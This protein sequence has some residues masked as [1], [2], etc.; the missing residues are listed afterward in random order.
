MSAHAE[1]LAR[2]FLGALPASVMSRG[3][4]AIEGR[5][6]T[7]HSASDRRK[8]GQFGARL[9]KLWPYGY[10]LPCGSVYRHA[11]LWGAAN[12]VKGFQHEELIVGFGLARGSRTRIDS[13]MKIRGESERVVLPPNKASEIHSF[14]NE[15]ERHTVLF[16][17]NHP[18]GHPIL[19]LLGLVLGNDPLPSL[20]D[21]NFAIGAFITRL[22]TKMQ[23]L[24]FGRLRFYLVQNDVI[25]EFSGFTPALLL[26]ALR[27]VAPRESRTQSL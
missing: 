20:T 21:R 25:S 5:R 16:V 6:L 14:L 7:L 10:R 9:K 12:Y 22:Q 11:F 26:D 18:D 24:A 2:Q 15:S 23:G 27:L 1:K 8:G 3:L 13:V 4:S 19:W 17:H